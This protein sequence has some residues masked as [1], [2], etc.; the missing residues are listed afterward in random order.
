MPSFFRKLAQ[1]EKL[2]MPISRPL[3]NIAKGLHELRLPYKDGIY[4][5]FYVI[6]IG[7]AIYV[8]HGMKKKNQQIDKKTRELLLSR[9][10]GIK[11]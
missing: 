9:I 2:L 8:L 1:G 4:R 3:S 11:L 6:K 10:R 5:I 7:D